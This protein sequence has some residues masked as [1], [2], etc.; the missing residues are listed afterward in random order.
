MCLL[1]GF[2]FAIRAAHTTASAPVRPAP[3]AATAAQP[4]A[5][6]PAAKGA[7]VVQIGAF[8]ERANAER[9]RDRA[10]GAGSVSIE[11]AATG[12]GVIYRVRLGP[13]D[14]RDE[15]E[16]ARRKAAHLGFPDAR[17]ATR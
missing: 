2:A 10:E 5:F 7:Y 17:I 12:G 14:D 6:T 15:A 9:A 4:A 11:Q 8:S 13:W 16:R 3:I 1:S